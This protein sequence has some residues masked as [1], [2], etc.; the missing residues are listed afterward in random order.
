MRTSTPPVPFD[1]LS[2]SFFACPTFD[3]SA[4][5]V[6]GGSVVEPC[7]RVLQPASASGASRNTHLSIVLAYKGGLHVPTPKL[8]A[9]AAV[10][11]AGCTCSRTQAPPDA[12]ADAPSVADAASAEVDDQDKE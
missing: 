12:A 11:F 9:L 8:V 2:A 6:A 7:D 5:T 10:V 4:A 3:A 1:E